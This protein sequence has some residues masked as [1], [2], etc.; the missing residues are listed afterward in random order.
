MTTVSLSPTAQRMLET[1]PVYYWGNPWV[2]RILQG[3]ADEIDKVDALLDS[4]KDGFVPTLADDSLGMLSIWEII[5]RVPVAPAGVTIDQRHATLRG[6]FLRLS[7]ATAAD[8]LALLEAQGVGFS[9]TRDDPGALQDTLH[10]SAPEGSYGAELLRSVAEAAWPDHRE[11][12]VA[13]AG[14]FTLDLSE[15]DDAEM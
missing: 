4:I 3:W 7:A 12:V 5:M 9:I 14:G 8:V 6:A 15:L 10:I 11:L 1:L 13:Y 2:E